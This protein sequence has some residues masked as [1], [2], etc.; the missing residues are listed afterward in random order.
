MRYRKKE[1][2]R[3]IES[4][5]QVNQIMERADKNILPVMGE[6][7]EQSQSA[8][9]ELG[10]Y[11]ETLGEKTD[12]IV[13]KLE[14]YCEHI[15]QQSIH[16]DSPDLCRKIAKRIR[17]QLC[18]VKDAVKLDLPDDRREAVFL[19]YKASMWDSLESVWMAA[20]DDENCDAYVI[21]IPYFEKNQDG[22]LGQMYDEGHE[23]PDY[24]P[25]TSWQEYSMEDHRPD[26]VFIHNP[27]DECN[28]VTSVHPA[29]Y[30]KELKKYTDMLVYIPYFIGIGNQVEEHF[31]VMPGTLYADQVIVESEEVRKQYIEELRKFE[32]ENRCQGQFGNPEKKIVALGSPKVEKVRNSKREQIL[33]PEEWQHLLVREDGTRKKVVL[34]NTTIGSL[35]KFSEVVIEKIEGVLKTFQ[36]H[37]DIVLLWRPHPLLLST[38]RSMRPRLY[39]EFNRVVE[40]YRQEGWGIYDDTADLER[41]IA[42]SDAYY[43]DWSSVVT[44][45]Q[46]A[47]KPIMIQAYQEESTEK[48]EEA[49]V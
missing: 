9:I 35:L 48:E 47:G 49:H 14:E 27:Y 29:F 21:P 22:S 32:K 7:L 2:L 16:L 4:L 17:R 12:P 15:Y 30:A 36:E 34:Y 25:V 3:L 31:C 5:E 23:Y 10:T 43:G 46:A 28:Y 24:V 44:L 20:R 40:K 18:Q 45:Y 11:L 33:I 41:A 39:G 42:L 19:P 8:A 13:K 6:A 26:M 1:L 38:I 37:E